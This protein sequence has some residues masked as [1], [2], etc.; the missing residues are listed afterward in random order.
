MENHK[1]LQPPFCSPSP[2]GIS[3][4]IGILFIF[5]TN[6][7]L[8]SQKNDKNILIVSYLSCTDVYTIE[9]PLFEILHFKTVK[10]ILS[11]AF[12]QSVSK[13]SEKLLIIQL[14]LEAV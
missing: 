5:L 4:Q 14:A 13:Q 9:F 3:P 6:L 2:V 8:R 10:Q 11:R 12:E 1:N 7:H